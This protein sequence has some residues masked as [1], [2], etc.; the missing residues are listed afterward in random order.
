V[1]LLLYIQHTLQ[2]SVFLEN[3]SI[4]HEK[5]KYERN[6]KSELDKSALFTFDFILFFGRNDTL[7]YGTYFTLLVA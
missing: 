1:S 7:Y 3:E 4:V 5:I 6:E 2:I